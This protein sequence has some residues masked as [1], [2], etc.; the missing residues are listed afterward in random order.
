M[1]I[2]AGEQLPIPKIFFDE[3]TPNIRVWHNTKIGWP[4][5]SEPVESIKNCF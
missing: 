5:S 3:N 2:H 1:K 4:L